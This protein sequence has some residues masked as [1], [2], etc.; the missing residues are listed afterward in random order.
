MT[1]KRVR[2]EKPDLASTEGIE[3]FDKS[4]GHDRPDSIDV[5]TVLSDWTPEEA[6]KHL[7]KSVR[8][9]RRLLQDGSLEGYKVPGKRRDEWR[10]KPVNLS[11]YKSVTVPTTSSKLEENDRLWQLLQEKDNKIESLVMRNGYLEAVL[12]ERDKQIKLLTDT[13]QEKKSWWHN[14]MKWLVGNQ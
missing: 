11:V 13:M 3:L 9:I 8:T 7:G 14:F 1:A 5:E 4:D 12:S 6:A 2:I 10:V